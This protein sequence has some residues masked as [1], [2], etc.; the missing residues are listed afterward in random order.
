MDEFTSG[1]EE[2]RRMTERRRLREFLLGGLAPGDAEALEERMFE[3]DAVY[4]ELD[5]E[6]EALVEEYVAGSLTDEDAARF[7]RQRRLSPEIATEV[8]Y[9]RDLKTLL[10]RRKG[11]GVNVAGTRSIW[12]PL[13]VAISVCILGLL[14]LFGLQ[15]RQNRRLGAELAQMAAEPHTAAKSIPV[16]AGR[17][18]GVVFLAT[19]VVRGPQDAVHVEIPP[20]A[21]LVQLQIQVPGVEDDARIWEVEVNR[22]RQ[23]IFRCS[24]L[25]ARRAGSIR[26]LPVYIAGEAL[27][28]GSYSVRIRATDPGQG[29][30][31]RMFT[32][33]RPSSQSSQPLPQ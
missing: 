15:W 22:D 23:E 25:S 28:E 29:D 32:I 30:E 14:F 8:T 1:Q 24:A 31:I 26:Y 12:R 33:G 17:T 19:G 20:G 2:G 6:H 9:L 13:P 4:H 16:Q 10:K 5:K 27:T 18:D 21:S 7:E 11:S 3:D